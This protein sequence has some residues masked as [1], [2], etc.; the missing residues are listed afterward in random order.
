MLTEIQE[1]QVQKQLKNHN[2]ETYQVDIELAKDHVLKNFTVYKGVLRPEVVTAY[3]L[4][5]H[6][7][8]SNSIY[9][10]KTCIDMGSGSGIQ[11]IVMG[12]YGAKKVIFTDIMKPAYENTR[13]NVEQFNLT[14]ISLCLQGDLFQKVKEKADI[15]VFNHP[16]FPAKPTPEQSITYAMLDQGTLLQR[17]LD[18]AKNYLKPN[19][20]I[21]MP[22]YTMAGKVN[23]PLQQAPKKG[24]NVHERFKAKINKGLQQ[25]EIAISELMIS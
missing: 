17:F 16:F 11:G 1:K 25:G 12:L 3:Y 8:F 13:Q 20:R 14:D 22:Y 10:N 23:N 18:Q 7:F 21:I 24:Y 15:I 19:A 5:Q 6:L 9:K 2:H 4:A